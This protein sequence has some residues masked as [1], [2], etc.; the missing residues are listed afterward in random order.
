MRVAARV[1]LGALLWTGI[2]V[3]TE[4]PGLAGGRD[5]PAGHSPLPVRPLRLSPMTATAGGRA[6]MT[7]GTARTSWPPSRPPVA[8]RT[9]LRAV[10]PALQ[11]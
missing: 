3:W 9:G 5:A 4:R 6:R 11:L 2:G 8:S 1:V 10:R 7:P